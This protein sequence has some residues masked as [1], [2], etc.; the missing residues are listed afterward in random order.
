[1]HIFAYVNNLTCAR[2]ICITQYIDHAC[3]MSTI[4]LPLNFEYI[5]ISISTI[6]I[7]AIYNMNDDHT[8][9]QTT[10]DD[11]YI[12]IYYIGM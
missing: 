4:L 3:N 8:R 9:I 11:V 1:M 10:I 12:I 2:F 5:K 7:H 6:T